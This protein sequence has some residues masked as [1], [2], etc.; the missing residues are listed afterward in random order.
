[1][2]GAAQVAGPAGMGY[3]VG[4][5]GMQEKSVHAQPRPP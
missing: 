1:V 4:H 3:V 5:L 2:V